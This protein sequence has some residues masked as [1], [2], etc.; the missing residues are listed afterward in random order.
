MERVPSRRRRLLSWL[1]SI[2]LVTLMAV[3]GFVTVAINNSWW[4][5][6]NPVAGADQT[7]PGGSSIF[8]GAGVDYLSRTGLV[9]IRMDSGAALPAEQLGLEPDGER[10]IASERPLRVQVFGPDGALVVQD[11]RQVTLSTEAG[12]LIRV[13]VVVPVGGNFTS[14]HAQL[15]QVADLYGW[16]AEELETM[17][18]EIGA[19]KRDDPDSPATA[20]VGPGGEVGLAVTATLLADR[21]AEITYTAERLP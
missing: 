9:V 14:A 11:A 17:L 18:D 6:P 13:D 12:E 7:A 10:S 5:D 4:V 2:L 20:S 3:A 19:A 21:G 1:P 8:T 16:S 15:T